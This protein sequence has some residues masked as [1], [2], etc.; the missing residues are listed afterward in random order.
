MVSTPTAAPVDTTGWTTYVSERYSFAIGHPADWTVETSNHDWTME[1]D[2][3]L[4]GNT[5]EEAFMSPDGDIRVSAWAVPSETPESPE[6]VEAWAEQYCQASANTSCTDIRERAAPL[7]NERWDCHPGLLVP[8]DSDVQ[9]FF[10]GGQYQQMVVVAVWRPESHSSVADYGGSRAL[11]EAF[12]STM[13]VC[14]AR[15]GPPAGCANAVPR[16]GAS[17]GDPL[18]TSR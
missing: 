17:T 14:P 8:F 1:A 12:L 10:T 16:A 4:F 7:C 9:A 6:G 18:E 15:S 3:S 5:G 2:A 11:L 13:D